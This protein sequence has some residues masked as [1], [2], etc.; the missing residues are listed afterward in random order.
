MAARAG[1]DVRLTIPG[2]TDKIFVLDLTKSYC[3][4]LIA[5]GVKIYEMNNMF[6]HNKIAIFWWWSCCDWNM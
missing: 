1:V 5:S 6:N 2:L 3:K 4:D